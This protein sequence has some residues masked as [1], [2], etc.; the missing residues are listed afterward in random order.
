MDGRQATQ[1]ES[2]EQLLD[3][4]KAAALSVTKLYKSSVAAETKAR[5]DGYQD[6]LDDLVAFLDK[7]RQALGTPGLSKLR[8]WASDRR[9]GREPTP[10]SCESEDEAEK[11]G[12]ARPSEPPAE[13]DAGSVTQPQP[14]PE[15]AAPAV[16][17]PVASS[18]NAPPPPPF[19]VPTQDTF[20]FHSDHPYPDIE[21]L[22][23]SDSRPHA[24][25]SH[26]NPRPTRTRPNK[27]GLNLRA[28]GPLGR[29]AGMKR[30]MDFDDFF[31]GCLGGK[32]PFGGGGGKRSRH[33]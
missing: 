1:N 32:D 9:D 3:V 13:T 18:S 14:Q 12:N 26:H 2:P 27:S 24:G 5:S 25:M 10:Q 28:S 8:K 4:F 31:G 29:G 6:C 15:P 19:I 33:T 22:D 16:A 23:L 21:L 17:P 30:R 11:P 7:E 20:N